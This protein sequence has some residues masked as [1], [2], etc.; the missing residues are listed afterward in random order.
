MGLF[1]IR[2][3]VEVAILTRGL[4]F[5]TCIE[6]I[7]IVKAVVESAFDVLTGGEID[8]SFSTTSPSTAVKRRSSIAIRAPPSRAVTSSTQTISTNTI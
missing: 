3:A 7:T 8:D 6:A 1:S 4:V 5:G 2:G